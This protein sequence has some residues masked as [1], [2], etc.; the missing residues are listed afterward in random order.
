[1]TRKVVPLLVALSLANAGC[2]YTGTATGGWEM[3]SDCFR[4][5]G[6]EPV[7]FVDRLLVISKIKQKANEAWR[8]VC[9]AS[10][11][12]Q[13]SS[14][15]ADG[16]LAG[17]RDYVEAGG[18]GEPPGL[19]PFCYR[20]SC[21]HG[22]GQN[23]IQDWYAG[24]RYGSAVGKDSGLREAILVPLGGLPAASLKTPVSQT[25]LSAASGPS[26]SLGQSPDQ[27]HPSHT[28]LDPLEVLPSPRRS[29]S[30]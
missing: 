8:S 19:P 30:P 21:Y 20:L 3:Y 24:F 26:G 23:A 4:N 10:P 12:H 25:M 29:P 7:R 27:E 14:D 1:M 13:Y 15:Y 17:F 11:D 18:S 9:Q 5:L 28:A 22:T 2:C 16:F 6:E